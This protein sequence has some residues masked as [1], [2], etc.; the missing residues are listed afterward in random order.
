MLLVVGPHDPAPLRAVLDDAPTVTLPAR[1]GRAE[2]TAALDRLDGDRLLIAADDAGLGAVIRRLL[3]RDQLADVAIGLIPVG[4]STVRARLGL[5]TELA[6]AAAVALHGRPTAQGLLRDDHGGVT[7]DSALVLPESGP[8]VGMRSYVDEAELAS[9]EV[10]GLTVRPEPA[11]L[12]ADVSLPRRFRAHRSLSGRAVTV[13][14]DPARII[15]DG[16]E[17]NHLQTR[18]TWWFEPDRWRVARPD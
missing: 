3:R 5:P 17:H 13:S 2:L 15:I 10:R 8:T 7:L 14:C 16:V 6:A 4:P 12:R 18:C 11:G 9:G 1:P